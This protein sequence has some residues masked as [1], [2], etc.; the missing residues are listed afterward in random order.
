VPLEFLL[1]CEVFLRCYFYSLYRDYSTVLTQNG[2]SAT[3]TVMNPKFIQT[4][5]QPPVVLGFLV[6]FLL[7]FL[8]L[9]F[10]YWHAVRH[11]RKLTKEVKGVDLQKILEEYLKWAGENTENISQLSER[12]ERLQQSAQGHFQRVGLVRFNPF[13]D[14]GGDQSFALSLLDNEG[15]GIV[16]SSLHGRDVTRMY[17]KPVREGVEAGYEFSEEEKEAVKKAMEEA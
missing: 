12:L 16:I 4:L 11:Y 13:E 6:F 3:L 2:C 10:L 5:W 14:T 8:V 9:T 15:N 1:L 17:G 7:W